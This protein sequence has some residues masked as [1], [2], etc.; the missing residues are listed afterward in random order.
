MKL[1]FVETGEYEYEVLREKTS[2]G[3][4][5]H[6]SCFGFIFQES[7]KAVFPNDTEQI[8][9]FIDKKTWG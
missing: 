8:N 9:E 5:I 7:D 6:S 1:K 3:K 2:L 4:I